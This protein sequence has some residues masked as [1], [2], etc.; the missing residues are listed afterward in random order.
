MGHAKDGQV[1]AGLTAE[2]L[3]G[4][5]ATRIG[6]SRKELDAKGAISVAKLTIVPSWSPLVLDAGPIHAPHFMSTARAKE[7]RQIVLGVAGTEAAFL[8]IT[9]P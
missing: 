7:G 2:S 9:A 1:L 3:E 8:T 6:R 5:L 4:G